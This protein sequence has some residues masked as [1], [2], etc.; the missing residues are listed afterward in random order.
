MS[1]LGLAA[2]VPLQPSLN[3]TSM[4]SPDFVFNEGADILSPKNLAELP[5]A[6]TGVANP[7]GDLVFVPVSQYSLKDKK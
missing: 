1:V 4:A 7:S 6:A 2:Q 5:R 3:T